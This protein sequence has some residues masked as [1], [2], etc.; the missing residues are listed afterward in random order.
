MLTCLLH[1]YVRISNH[2]ILWS[3][4]ILKAQCFN[5]DYFTGDSDPFVDEPK[6]A[7]IFKRGRQINAIETCVS[8]AML[9]MIT[10]CLAYSPSSQGMSLPEDRWR[11]VHLQYCLM[12]L[13]VHCT[14]M[15]TVRPY[16]MTASLRHCKTCV[17]IHSVELPS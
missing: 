7:T 15:I 6:I 14:C 10:S 8:P 9:L 12:Y 3:I 1:L 17:G 11:K 2:S 5:L 4:F 13:E 16:E